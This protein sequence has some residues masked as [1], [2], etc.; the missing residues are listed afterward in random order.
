MGVK[1]FVSY[2]YEDKSYVAQLKDWAR[3][4]Q[5]GDVTITSETMDVRHKGED[6]IRQHLDPLLHASDG[7]VLL[8][9]RD[10]H[11]RPNTVE[12]EVHFILSQQKQVV[13]V[14]LPNTS[15]AAPIEVR[16]VAIHP[17]DPASLRSAIASAFR[18]K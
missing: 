10:T 9:G 5:L 1:L 3:T 11:D 15:G 2:V 14:R 4:G 17:F 6:A 13:L 7:A 16:G 8:V 12:R 18:P